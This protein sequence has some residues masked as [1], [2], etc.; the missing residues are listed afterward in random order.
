MG[1]GAGREVNRRPNGNEPSSLVI[2]R[3]LIPPKPSWEQFQEH[4]GFALPESSA[5]VET[6][7]WRGRN[8]PDVPL[9]TEAG[10]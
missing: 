5:A 3:L 6:P 8:V 10:P 4:W 1:D 9:G 7:L 2:Q